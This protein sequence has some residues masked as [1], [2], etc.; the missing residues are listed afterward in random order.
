MQSVKHRPERRNCRANPTEIFRRT[1]I[2]KLFP[3]AFI[4]Q[5][6]HKNV[7]FSLIEL[8]ELPFLLRPV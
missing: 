1:K 3:H 7:S 2:N 4:L 6:L 8:F 5:P